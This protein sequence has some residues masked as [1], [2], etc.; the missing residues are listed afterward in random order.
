MAPP[1]LGPLGNCLAGLN[2]STGPVYKDTKTYM[3][4]RMDQL[5]EWRDFPFLPWPGKDTPSEI[6]LY[7]LI[8][9]TYVLPLT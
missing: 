8:Q 7:T 4:V 2:G 1:N 6:H 9:I 3:P 5:S